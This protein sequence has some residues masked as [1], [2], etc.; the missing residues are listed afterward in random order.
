MKNCNVEIMNQTVNHT[1]AQRT[2]VKI[3]GKRIRERNEANVLQLRI[4]N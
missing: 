4:E 3:N 1:Q 2:V